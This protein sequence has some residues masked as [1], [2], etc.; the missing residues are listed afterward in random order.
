MSQ[1]QGVVSIPLARQWRIRRPYVY[2][3][4]KRKYV[5]QFFTDGLLRLSSFEQFSQHPDEPRRDESKGRGFLVHQNAQ[6]G[7]QTIVA[8]MSQGQDAYVLCGS[9]LYAPYLFE[10]FRC[11]YGFRIND[12][13]AFADAVAH[14]I[15]GF[16]G[17]CEGA[18]LY[19][20]R[21][22][23]ERDLGRIDLESLKADP[24]GNELDL[25]AVAAVL[26]GAVGDDLFFL[27]EAQPRFVKQ[28]EYRLLWSVHGPTSPTLAVHCP[29]ARQFCAPFDRLL[30]R[31]ADVATDS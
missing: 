4:L 16:R 27:K 6:D 26:T 20:P 10:D 30:G 3:Y 31:A 18:C 29:E 12:P 15:P 19:Q 25:G 14:R 2:R 7:G 23:V 13:T 21:R 24:V 22:W 9:T 1:P 17:G 5:D 28:Y 8:M 11:D